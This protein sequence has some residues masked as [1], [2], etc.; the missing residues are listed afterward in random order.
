MEEEE[1]IAEAEEDGIVD[2]VEEAGV[3]EAGVP[4]A[5]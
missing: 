1:A 2:E 5:L 4:W 3:K